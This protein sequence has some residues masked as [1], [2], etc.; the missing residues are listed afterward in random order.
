[1]LISYLICSHRAPRVLE[2][3]LR[4]VAMEMRAGPAELI[5]VNNGFDA[6]R[7]RQLADDFAFGLHVVGGNGAVLIAP[8]TADVSEHGGEVGIGQRRAHRRHGKV[9]FL[10][11]DL[12]APIQSRQRNMC[13]RRNI[14]GDPFG[15]GE[16][17]RLAGLAH[18][19]RAV[20][21][22]ANGIIKRFAGFAFAVFDVTGRA[23][24]LE[25]RLL[26]KSM[27]GDGGDAA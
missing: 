6:E 17:W 8:G 14:L 12:D 9:P 19:I 11:F 21:D 5:L 4:A 24:T 10:A 2:S 18:A 7:E 16:R 22:A 23:I 1:M 27:I 20:A 15:A 3:A 25:N 26:K 13:E